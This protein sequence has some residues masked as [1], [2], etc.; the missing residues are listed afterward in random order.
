MDWLLTIVIIVV[1]CLYIVPKL[2]VFGLCIV[3]RKLNFYASVGGPL[4]LN[5]VMLR[6]PIKMNFA[7]LIR[8][9]QINIKLGVPG[10]GII[11]SSDHLFN[12]F[13]RGLEVNLLL[14]DDFEKW[15]D[16]KFELLDVIG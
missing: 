11:I 7:I 10:F 3:L 6:I 9:E 12:I 2:I 14:R 8:V 1:A 4:T 15:N 13:I 16:S 5:N